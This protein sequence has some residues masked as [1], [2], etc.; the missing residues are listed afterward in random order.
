M[1]H[2]FVSVPATT[3]ARVKAQY[4]DLIIGYKNVQHHYQ[5]EDH[6]RQGAER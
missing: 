1:C 2:L 3:S 5:W 6:G 4:L